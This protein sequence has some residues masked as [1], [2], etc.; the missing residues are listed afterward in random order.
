VR[1][2]QKNCI[3]LEVQLS[4]SDQKEFLWKSSH[5]P[6]FVTMYVLSILQAFAILVISYSGMRISRKNSSIDSNGDAVVFDD[7]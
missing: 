5:D 1:K 3:N 6:N 4:L 2:I 7:I